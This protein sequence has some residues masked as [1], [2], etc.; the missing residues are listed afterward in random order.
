MLV[1][2]HELN[3]A[4]QFATSLVLLNEGKVACEG[5]AELVLSPAS[6][7]PI[8]GEGLTFGTMTFRGCETPAERPFVLP[9]RRGEG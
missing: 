6:L 3:L 9:W 4:S 5:S 8:Y 7:K 2:T 1:V